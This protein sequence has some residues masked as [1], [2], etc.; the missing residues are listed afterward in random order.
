M[1]NVVVIGAGIGGIA[2]SIRMAA[3]GYEVHVYEANSSPG[4]KLTEFQGEGYRF[5]FGPSLF[6]LP[7][8]VDELFTL[9]GLDPREFFNYETL[10]ES[11]RYFYEDGLK[12]TAYTDRAKLHKLYNVTQV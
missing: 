7:K 1:K 11:C 3:K 4:G 10:T 12:L 8:L 2:T 5:D 9:C 6:T